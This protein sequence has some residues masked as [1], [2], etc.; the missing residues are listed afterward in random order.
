MASD[1]YQDHCGER[2][3][4]YGRDGLLNVVVALDHPARSPVHTCMIHTAGASRWILL[5]SIEL[6]E[7]PAIKH[8]LTHSG[9]LGIAFVLMALRAHT[10]RE[11]SERMP[12]LPSRI[13]TWLVDDIES[14]ST[15]GHTESEPS[16]LAAVD[17]E[18]QS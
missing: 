11:A 7:G 9:L 16:Q 10:M 18:R 2:C 8:E 15:G 5:G 12:T 3:D 1:Y 4:I 17:E 13:L 14:N 6:D